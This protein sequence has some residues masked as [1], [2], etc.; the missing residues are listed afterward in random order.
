M[1]NNK[2]RGKQK[3]IDSKI[4]KSDFKEGKW[5]T[6][7]EDKLFK[8]FAAKPLGELLHNKN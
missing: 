6:S 4:P 1:R 3:R 8:P 7:T 5:S 2:Y